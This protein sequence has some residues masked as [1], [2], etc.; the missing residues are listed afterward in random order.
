MGTINSIILLDFETG[1]VDPTKNPV[2]QVAYQAFEIDTLKPILEFQTY[3]KPYGELTVEEEAL[4]YSGV[5]YQ[6]IM[7]GMDIKDVVKKM[8]EDF[9]AANT[10]NTYTKKP[11]IAG[12][13]IG[14]DIGFLIF[15]FNFCKADIGKYFASNK[16]NLG[17]EVPRYIDTE[18]LAKMT[19]G[20]DSK[21]A[22][23]KLGTCIQKAGLDL[24]DA[25]GAM[26]DVKGNKDLLL[27]MINN[28]RNASGEGVKVE[29]QFTRLRNHFKF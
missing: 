13:N 3:I 9:S 29:S 8:C 21:M 10:A 7:T 4:E 14:F 12:H 26:N 18:P 2:T 5:T 16:N 15:M 27:F 6:Q 17:Q 23:Y 22:N 11:F 20:T 19:W 24:F 1:G 28:L 25:H